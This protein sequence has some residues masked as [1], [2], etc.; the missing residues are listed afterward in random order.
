MVQAA[1]TLHV[2]TLTP[3]FPSDH[4]EVTGCFVAEPIEKFSEFGL[5]SS[6]IAVSAIHHHRK[7]STS[8]AA[9]EWVRYPQFPGAVG[10]SS[11]GK[12]LYARLLKRVRRLH[13]LKP[14]DVIHAHAALPC[15]HAAMLLSRR[16]KIPFVVTVHGRDVFNNCYLGGA[17][18]A[19]RRNVSVEV[20]RAAR[21]IVCISRKVQEILKA[22]MPA[23]IRS[24]IVHNGVNPNLFSPN[25]F[26]P[27]GSDLEILSVGMLLESKGHELVLR[28][29]AKLRSSF[30]K[31]RCSIVGEGPDRARLEA[32]VRDLDIE[33]QVQFIARQSRAEVAEAMRRC[34]VFALASR[35]EGLG[36][37][38]LEA[39][40]CGK[41]VIGCRGQGVDE[42]V[43]HGKNGWLIPADGLEE[44][45]QG[46]S[47][48][49]GS[50]ELR[51]RLG[52]AAR[53]T[54]VERFTLSHQAR[55]LAAIYRAALA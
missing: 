55:Q 9:A 5:E 3:F 10:L 22:G 16:L 51:S 47:A 11:A 34:S 54:I 45:V 26:D 37:V 8:Q 46:L 41:P 33:R 35:N 50:P 43:D 31:V 20:Y 14:I 49:L 42:V 24:S 18:A 30:P 38:Y 28:A 48:L 7:R 2:L 17:P 29:L 23:E 44:L 4:N 36:C 25:Q 32:L 19:W 27:V 39:M 1:P 40:S 21:N 12:L 52:A 6:V 13:R 53:Q 15:G